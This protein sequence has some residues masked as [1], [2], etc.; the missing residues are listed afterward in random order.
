MTPVM[1]PGPPRYRLGGYQE[2]APPP[3][4]EPGDHADAER[5]LAGVS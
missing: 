2:H 5:D 4:L 1:P 3:Y